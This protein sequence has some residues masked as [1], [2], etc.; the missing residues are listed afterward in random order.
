MKKRCVALVFTLLLPMV[1]P[2]CSRGPAISE[3][4][5]NLQAQLDSTFGDGLWEVQRFKRY[6]S[7]PWMGNSDGESD[8][9]VFYYHAELQLRREWRFAAWDGQGRSPLH[10]LLNA[11]ER[12]VE[13]L[14]ANGNLPGDSI[15]VHGFALYRQG[16]KGWSAVPVDSVDGLKVAL[17]SSIEQTAD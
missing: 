2:G 7:Q 17:S 4:Q 5:G 13:G 16:G 14:E 9:W 15:S 6:G 10:H 12:G 3:L 8:Q 1:L 11:A